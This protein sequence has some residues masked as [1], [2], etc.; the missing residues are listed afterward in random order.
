MSS[1]AS[2]H[3]D[4]A[5]Q[6]KMHIIEKTR[7]CVFD[8][9]SLEALVCL[10]VS[11]IALEK[12]DLSGP[13]KTTLPCFD[14]H[15]D[16]RLLN[17][18]LNSDL[19]SWKCVQY[20]EFCGGDKVYLYTIVSEQYVKCVV[21]D[22]QGKYYAVCAVKSLTA[23]YQSVVCAGV[24]LLA[25]YHLNCSRLQLTVCMCTYA[26]YMQC[27]KCNVDSMQLQSIS[28]YV[29]SVRRRDYNA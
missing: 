9:S 26:L 3:R 7:R 23:F 6:M 29:C 20:V 27:S 18:S 25:L 8:K 17:A 4:L 12:P 1:G 14:F 21:C 5:K 24:P 22:V 28:V 16:C 11:R 10:L 13:H 19:R 2:L 15:K